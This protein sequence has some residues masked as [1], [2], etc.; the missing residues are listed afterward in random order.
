[1]AGSYVNIIILQSEIVTRSFS[2]LNV[3][4]FYFKYYIEMCI[5]LKW[6]LLYLPLGIEEI[7]F[8]CIS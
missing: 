8:P 7:L 1:M 4:I 5:I 3:P 6:Y 2:I